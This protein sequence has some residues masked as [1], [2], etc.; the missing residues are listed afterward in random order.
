MSGLDYGTNG[1]VTAIDS[2]YKT[3]ATDIMAAGTTGSSRTCLDWAIDG[4]NVTGLPFMYEF[5]GNF[6]VTATVPATELTVDTIAIYTGTKPA[7]QSSTYYNIGGVTQ[8]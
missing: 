4:F 6:T 1:C 3:A 7:G 5:G 8:V 2:G